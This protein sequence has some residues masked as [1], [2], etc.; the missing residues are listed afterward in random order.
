MI[1]PGRVAGTSNACT[2]DDRRQLT[3]MIEE[4]MA[5]RIAALDDDGSDGG[6]AEAIEVERYPHRSITLVNWQS[7]KPNEDM[8]PYPSLYASL[9]FL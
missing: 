5:T 3:M 9:R 2:D 8:E 7:P 6:G 1:I 4:G